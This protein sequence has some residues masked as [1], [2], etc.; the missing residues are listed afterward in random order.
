MK[1]SNS[2][3]LL[4]LVV[5][6]ARSFQPRTAS[7]SSI[8]RTCPPSSSSSSRRTNAIAVRPSPWPSP[9]SRPPPR[10]WQPR[11]TSSSSALSA[12]PAAAAALT[13]LSSPLGS[14]AVLAFVILVH[15]A[16][17]FLAARSL[18]IRVDEFSVGV[19]PRIAGVRRTKKTTTTTTT[20]GSDEYVFDYRWIAGETPD[21]ERESADSQADDIEFSLRALPLGG[22]VRFPE[23]YN[24]TLAYEM[25]DAVRLAKNQ[26]L[27]LR[28]REESITAWERVLENVAA[29]SFVANALTLGALGKWA[30]RR[31]EGQLR[32][33]EEE[34]RR[35]ESS[36][37]GTMGKKGSWFDALPWMKNNDGFDNNKGAEY[38]ATITSTTADEDTLN[39][40][41]PRSKLEIL[42][43]ATTKP[44]ITYSDDPDLLQNRP[45]E[46]R[47]LVLSGGVVFNILLAFACYFGEVTEGRGLPRP[48]FESGAVVSSVVGP[49]SPAFGVLVQ[50]DVIVGVND[51]ITSAVTDGNKGMWASQ[52][53]ISK[54][55]STIR[56]TPEGEPVKLTILH[57]KSDTTAIATNNNI[58]TP[59]QPET[60]TVAPKRKLDALG[61]PTGPQSIGVMLAPNYLRTDMIKATNVLDAITK[62]SLAVYEITSE[63]AKSIFGLLL[64]LLFGKGLPAGTSMSGPIG[65]ISTG[66][67]VVSSRDIA[68]IVAFAASI[69][70]NLAVVNSLPLPALDGGQ[71]LFV[72]AEAAAGRKIDQRL[73]EGINAGALLVLLCISFGTAVGDVTSI[74]SR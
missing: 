62:S 56:E 18:G 4:L 51:M 33:A 1:L 3:V 58:N 63:T 53:E 2:A 74:F 37:N 8:S 59:Q 47:A 60:V 46:Q 26:A 6:S 44:E 22:Y 13:S 54:V 55:I 21:E 73:Q 24:R 69:S 57:G 41:D 43:V 72:L 35:L 71:L 28:L 25:D 42:Q 29:R 20:N 30:E 9:S 10:R 31:L 27:K 16:G 36:E 67:E 65:V 5:P 45:W 32:G 66:S 50:G 38:D 68:T 11:P 17:H 34:V 40:L 70:V 19:G 23:N 14:L 48:V 52:K 64:D 12:L 61:Q 7:S 49:E 39:N 15:E